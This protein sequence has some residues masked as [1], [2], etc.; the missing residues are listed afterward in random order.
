ME[1]GREVRGLSQGGTAPSQ[2]GE[3]DQSPN[4]GGP[5]AACDPD[6]Q[7]SESLS[8]CS[9]HVGVA[10]LLPQALQPGVDPRNR[11]AER[12][13]TGSARRVRFSAAPTRPPT[14]SSSKRWKLKACAKASKSSCMRWLI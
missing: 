12:K 9:Q 1:V 14:A 11:K 7:D 8:L 2:R 4:V 13:R 5:A 3:T 10:L 6:Q